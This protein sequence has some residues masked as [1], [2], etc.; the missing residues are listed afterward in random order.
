MPL[1][2]LI[3]GLTSI[4]GKN[5][6]KTVADAVKRYNGDL[7]KLRIKEEDCGEAIRALE[8]AKRSALARLGEITVR[9]GALKNKPDFGYISFS[10]VKLL[11]YDGEAFARASQDPDWFLVHKLND[12]GSWLLPRSVALDVSEDAAK[13][14]ADLETDEKKMFQDFMYYDE[15]QNLAEQFASSLGAVRT[16]YDKHIKVLD[17]FREK[18]GKT[19]WL[20]F[21]DTEKFATQNAVQLS[22]LIYEMCSAELI[23]EC[24]EDKDNSE[25]INRQGIRD[26]MA[27]AKALC[28]NKGFEYD[29]QTYD[30]ILRGDAKSYFSYRYRLEDRL[31]EMLPISRDNTAQILE[32]L[33][34]D[35]NVSIARDVTQPHARTMLDK[36]RDIDIK[37]QRVPSPDQKSIFYID[38][39]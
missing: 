14:W 8:D 33:R 13:T 11:P 39:I 6:K 3:G 30:V 19:D 34:M 37:S 17:T 23:C 36:L 32:K 20:L 5:K 12:A 16:V 22:S 27:K 25:W 18:T 35:Q 2:F 29:G 26:L 10:N 7:E 31:V 21:N 9:V 1:P 28:E 15:L 4:M 38:L 24:G